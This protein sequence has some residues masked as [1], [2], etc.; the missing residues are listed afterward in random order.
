MENS[1]GKNITFAEPNGTFQF[2]ITHVAGY[3][4]LTKNGTVSV[5]GSPV[6]VAVSFSAN[7]VSPGSKSSS[8]TNDLYVISL[9]SVSAVI[10]AL[11]LF[12][13][14]RKGLW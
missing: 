6:S 2:N 13:T 7:T 9:I 3:S 5:S 14:K 11:V 12:I 4:T 1:I 8:G 10:V